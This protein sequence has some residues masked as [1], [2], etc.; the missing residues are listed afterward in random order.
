MANQTTLKMN[1][2]KNAD[3]I[4]RE[5]DSG[6][7]Q[8][9]DRAMSGVL[10]ELNVLMEFKHNEAIK[11]AVESGLGIGCLSKIVLRRSLENGDLVPL[12]LPGRPMRR[13][14]YFALPKNYP[15]TAA[16]RAWMDTCIATNI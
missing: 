8:T 1:D 7:R 12:Q 9:F 2:I 14:F 5:P 11:N 4:L 6:A 13:V 3:W 10:P 15:E 16:I